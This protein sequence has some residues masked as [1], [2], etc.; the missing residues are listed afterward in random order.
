MHRKRWQAKLCFLLALEK[1][2]AKEPPMW[3]IFSWHRW[4]KMR[5]KR[6]DYAND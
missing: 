4:K 3:K 5:P 6:E 2:M 1:W